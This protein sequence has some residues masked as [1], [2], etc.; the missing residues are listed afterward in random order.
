VDTNPEHDFLDM[1]F[2]ETVAVTRGINIRM[3]E[4][5]PEA[6]AWLRQRVDPG[7]RQQNKLQAMGLL[8]QLLV[9]LAERF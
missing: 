5:P 1:Q 8:I 4:S 2:A 3:F 6:E 9:Q 7:S